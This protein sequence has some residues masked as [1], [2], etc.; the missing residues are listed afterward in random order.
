MRELRTLKL[1]LAVLLLLGAILM[2]APAP[3]VAQAGEGNGHMMKDGA[4]AQAPMEHPQAPT[5]FYREHRFL[6]LLGVGIGGVGFFAYRAGRTRWRRK[7]A[8]TEFATEAVLVVDL[9]GSTHLATHYGK[10]VAMRAAE[11]LH[12]RTL[13]LAEP[14]GLTFLKSTGDG[15]LITFPR[16]SDA[17]ETAVALLRE[18]IDGPSKLS[19][20]TRLELRAGISYGEIIV[21][22]GNDRFGAAINKAFRIEGLSRESF[23]QVEGEN[24]KVHEIADRNRIFLDEEASH[25][26]NR[27]AKGKF[28]QYFLGFARLKGF[29]GLH[30]VY[31]VHWPAVGRTRDEP[32]K[33]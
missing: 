4:T 9:V 30:R 5:P 22:G 14:R 28:L 23:T 24:S 15:C 11:I 32:L 25:E 8:P 31:E 27:E 6:I 13:A 2:M 21:D 1:F 16:V 33:R 7:K 3:A 17:C 20:A 26:L 29:S 12:D 10:G 18:L 19:A